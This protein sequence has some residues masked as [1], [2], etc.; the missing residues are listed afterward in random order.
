MVLN[1]PVTVSSISPV[2]RSH[3]TMKERMSYMSISDS[4]STN[5]ICATYSFHP[6]TPFG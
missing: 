6:R 2:I 1:I 5:T 3:L 4:Y